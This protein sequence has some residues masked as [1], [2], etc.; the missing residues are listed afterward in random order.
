MSVVRNPNLGPSHMR[1]RR[2]RLF[3]IRFYIILFFLL[4]I[5]FGLAILSGHEKVKIKNI[6]VTGNA[7]VSTEEILTVVNKNL[8]GR[9]W[10]L[11]ARSDSTIFPRF[12]IKKELLEN[13]L[14]IKDAHISWEDWQAISVVVTER[15]P[16]SVWCGA[17]YKAVDTPCY[18][19][20]KEG[21][22]YSDAPTFSGSIFIKDY[23]LLTAT[24]TPVGEHFLSPSSYQEIF[25]LIQILEER[26]MKVIAVSYDGKDYRFILES[27]PEIIFNVKDSFSNLFTALETKSLDLEKDSANIKYLD[28]RFSNKIVIGKKNEQK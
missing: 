1:Q 3:F 6:L 8:I 2:R 17:D 18:F 22:I 20:D 28:L 7:S 27:G 16:H 13:I 14:T 5:I 11:F 24:S 21:L 23:S 26:N 10:Y 12:A 4:A 25:N 15:K 19:V 9:Y